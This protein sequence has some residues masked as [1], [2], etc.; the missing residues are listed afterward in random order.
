MAT[1]KP[2]TKVYKIPAP[3][4]APEFKPL[5]EPVKAPAKEP[6]TVRVR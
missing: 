4:R 1:M 5:L 6:V 2:I 3:V